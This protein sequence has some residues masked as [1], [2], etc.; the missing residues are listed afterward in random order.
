MCPLVD[1][2][3]NVCISI[4]HDP[5][6]DK[7]GYERPEERWLPIHTV[8]TIIV[9]VISMLSEPN[10][11]SPANVDAAKMIRENPAEFRRRVARTVR[12]TQEDV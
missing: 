5:G 7:W 8:E 12:L 2:T 4:L 6:E 3:G 9:S 1:S 11:E 10:P